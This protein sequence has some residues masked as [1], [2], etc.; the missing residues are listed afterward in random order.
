MTVPG[1][2]GAPQIPPGSS[3][4][5]GTTTS[6]FG[7]LIP[8]P[9][10]VPSGITSFPSPE[11]IAAAA[12]APPPA[13]PT[14][15]DAAPATT[16][17][18]PPAARAGNPLTGVAAAPAPA[19]VLV[20]PPSTELRVGG[21][22][23]LVPISVSGASRLSTVSLSLTFN[24]AVMRVRTVQEGP[25][26][27]QGGVKATFTHKVDAVGGRVDIAVVRGADVLGASGTGLVAAIMFDAV[28]PGT[29]P[30]A[31]SG[32]GTLAGGGV[33]PLQFQPVTVSVK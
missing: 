14:P 9:A 24:P 30:L 15:A 1:S 18:P 10:P 26:M 17:P 4:I 28:A 19:R 16:A 7:T 2:V 29:S 12:A 25:L 33:A 23:Y 5:P 21:G 11:A 8:Q 31:L 32:V 22:P 13:T 3:A 6:L 20:S 27:Q